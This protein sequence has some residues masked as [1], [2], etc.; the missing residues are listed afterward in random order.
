M[1]PEAR[2]VQN[3]PDDHKIR[4]YNQ[5]TETH[6]VV[7]LAARVSRLFGATVQFLPNPRNELEENTLYVQHQKLPALGL[8]PTLLTDQYMRTVYNLATQNRDNFIK[9]SV[10]RA[11]SWN[12]Q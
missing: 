9:A 12:L 10:N 2:R 11:H 5:T 6:R 3:P 7:D 1:V 4:I 8:S